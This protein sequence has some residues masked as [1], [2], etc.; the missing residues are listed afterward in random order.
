MTMK[1]NVR[2]Y[3]DLGDL[4][5]TLDEEMSKKE[6]KQNEKKTLNK[7]TKRMVRK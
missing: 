1:I 6:M 2:D 7:N 4:E 5:E 3:Q